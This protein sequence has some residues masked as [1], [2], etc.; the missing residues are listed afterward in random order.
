MPKDTPILDPKKE[1][2]KAERQKNEN[3]F[4]NRWKLIGGQKYKREFRFH[5]RRKWRFDFAIPEVKVA[6]EIDP[7]AHKLYWNSYLRD[8]KKM[9]EA[10]FLG[11]QVFRITGQMI[12]ADDVY[13][14]EKLKLYID[15]KQ[16]AI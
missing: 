6:V 4:V 5:P 11:W 10:L 13:F 12:K 8:V 2:K 1:L 14:L 16:K 9:N 3:W 7:A 15:E